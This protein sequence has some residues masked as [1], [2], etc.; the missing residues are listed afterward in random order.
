MKII[1][2]L[3]SILFFIQS[4]ASI[5]TTV[6]STKINNV[7]VFFNGAEVQR[8]GELN[9]TKGKHI[10][11]A[12]QLPEMIN[13]QSIQ[14]EATKNTT[15]L[16]V[17]HEVAYYNST[18]KNPFI[19]A[20]E[21]SIEKI[22][23]A[24][25][26]LNSEKNVL[27]IE[28]DILLKNSQ[29][30]GKE[31]GVS[32][33][34]LKNAAEYYRLRLNA[35]RNQMI[36]IEVKIKAKKEEMIKE[37]ELLNRSIAKNKQAYSKIII[38]VENSAATNEK[39]TLSYYTPTAGWIPTYDFRV[40]DI[41][42]PLLIV[43][44]ANVYQSSGE[45]W[46]KVNVTL[47]TNDPSLSGNKPELDKW[48][49]GETPTYL[50]KSDNNPL[51]TQVPSYGGVSAVKGTVLD[52]SNEEPL[53]FANVTLNKGDQQIIGTTTDFD[54]NYMLKPIEPGYY[55]I[56]VTY[57][58]YQSKKISGI[59]VSSDNITIQNIAIS[60]GVALNEV[61][62]IEY[63]KPLIDIDDASTGRSYTREEISGQVNNIRGS[64]SKTQGTFIDGVK[65][66][67]SR[68]LIENEF[69]SSTLSLEYEIKI[70]YTIPSDGKDYNIKIKESSVPVNYEYFIV[71]KI[72][73]D[74][75]LVAHIDDWESLNLLSGKSSVYYQ[76]KF[77]GESY[78]DVDQ[79][80][81]TLKV[82]LGREKNIFV[83]RERNKEI[84]DRQFFSNNIKETIGWDIVIKNN[85][86]FPVKVTVEDQYPISNRK[87]VEVKL[88][89][90]E[91]AVKNEKPGLLT[92]SFELKKDES[93]TI[94]MSYEAKYPRYMNVKYY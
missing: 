90:A 58:G 60:Q 31:K 34:E 86:N 38:A 4:Q 81:D 57:V 56:V 80:D 5:D 1:S 30:S 94:F 28:E 36:D 49:L 85:K 25:T 50:S 68:D 20:K 29:L 39:F 70:P 12:D 74:A 42:E 59:N 7:T 46:D 83:S 3:I 84:D 87:S 75:F 82:S 62:V 37:Y 52:D 24:V 21:E 71:P 10:L 32:V 26:R 2:L 11:I 88:L 27:E 55:D 33:E 76:G 53:P 73:K 41:N 35:I 13:P 54:G 45:N 69:K 78:V 63:S 19:K 9:L 67:G 15:I 64:R 22:R 91:N 72:E 14:V 23:I 47:S 18:K 40:K 65:V 89:S 6:L 92:W 17:K 77:T 43:Y 61:E 48:I 66:I 16:S 93:K 79:S 8:E 51:N 44:N